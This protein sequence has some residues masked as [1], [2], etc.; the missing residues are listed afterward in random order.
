MF[1]G[2][3]QAVGT[4]AYI[5]KPGGEACLRTPPKGRMENPPS[6]QIHVRGLPYW[7][8]VG[9]SVAIDGCCLTHRGDRSLL[10]FDL[11]LETYDRTT[12]GALEEGSMVYVETALR[13][14]DPIGGHFVTGH[15]DGVGVF[16]GSEG[17]EY[18]FR[19]PDGGEGFLVDKGS[20]AIAGVSLTVV[21]P[22]GLEFS[23][24]V[25]P[26]TLSATTLGALSVGDGVNIEYDVLARY[27][28]KA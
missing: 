8:P 13:A 18:R 4:V 27:A 21:R 12:L 22:E 24:A 5:G 10:E 14:G 2:I 11:S 6:L 15:V 1:T 3:V 16:L 28:R 19:V 26:H 9:G 25:I 20:I 17:E 23:V 7:P